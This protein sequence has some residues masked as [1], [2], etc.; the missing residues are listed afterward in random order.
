MTHGSLA[1]TYRLISW[2]NRHESGEISY[3]LG[4]D[5]QGMINYSRDGCMFVHIMA[6]NRKAYSSGD[7]FA[8]E[9]SEIVAGATS[10]IS[11][12]GTYALDEHDVIHKVNISSFPNWVSTEQRRRFEFK[13]GNLLLGAQGLRSGTETVAAY[14]I[15]QP[16]NL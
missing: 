13:D 8:G 3:P 15:W 4:P 7:L 14:L 2:E 9:T 6:A 5:A 11:Y 16:L 10:H 1:G 12:C